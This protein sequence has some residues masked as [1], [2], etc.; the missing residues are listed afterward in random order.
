LVRLAV[1]ALLA[2]LP[3]AGL[4]Q[5]AIKVPRIA[6]FTLGFAPDSP[7][8][9]AFHAALR[10]HGYIDGQNIRIEYVFAHG[11]TDRLSGLASQL[12]RSKV[13]LIVTEGTPT[14][15]A[16]RQATGT[17][18]I[19][20]AVVADPIK[21]GLASSMS[22]PGGNVTGVT[23]AVVERGPKQLELLKEILPKGARVAVLYNDSITTNADRI[24]LYQAASQSLGLRLQTIAVRGPAD[25][26]NAFDTIRNCRCSGFMTMG[27]G[28]LWAQ[29][30]R[31]AS[32]ATKQRLAAA[33]PEREFAEEGGLIAYGPNL[34][35]NFRRAATFVDKILK[36][37][38]PADLPIEQPTKVDLV[39]NLKT[40]TALGIKMPHS[41]LVRADEVIQ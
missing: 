10:E 4:A 12:A 5:S 3:F 1:L 40:A 38:K 31:I 33:F 22:R 30:Q 16:A 35:T 27:D 8:V 13:D 32:F 21:L 36:G 19:V 23:F 17:I 41:L 9:K 26:D 6:L 18:P 20:T 2:A 28:M 34:S 15:V 11:H 14:A 7:P 25:L 29:R 37:A 39:I 24:K